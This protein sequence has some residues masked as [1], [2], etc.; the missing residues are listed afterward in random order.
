MGISQSWSHVFNFSSWWFVWC[1][2]PHSGHAFFYT[3]T[4]RTSLFLPTNTGRNFFSKKKKKPYRQTDDDR[5]ISNRTISVSRGR[6]W[7][8][9]ETIASPIMLR[10]FNYIWNVWN[11]MS[12]LLIYPQPRVNLFWFLRLW[13][14]ILPFLELATNIF[15]GVLH[16]CTTKNAI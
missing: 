5:N 2:F 8:Q 14:N 6:M 3:P 16:W 12:A 11:T 1:A 10:V 13:R 9:E 7:G 4:R 15:Q